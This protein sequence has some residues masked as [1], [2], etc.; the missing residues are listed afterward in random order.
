MRYKIA[1]IV[2]ALLLTLGVVGMAG[3]Q[4]SYTQFWSNVQMM[5]DV[6]IEEDLIVQDDVTI[7]DDLTVTDDATV[8]GILTVTE[9]IYQAVNTSE[10]VGLLPTVAS[11]DVITSTSG[12]IFTIADGE[13]WIVHGVLVAITEN[14]D[15]DGNDCTMTIGDGGDVDGLVVLADSEM[16]AAAVDVTGGAAGVHGY[17]SDTLGAY[18]ADSGFFMYAP[19]GAAETIDFA[20]GG[21]TPEGGAATVYIIYTRVE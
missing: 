18:L 1:A 12:A 21:T 11:V 19:S 4:G 15:C 14:F 2:L 9:E 10:N 5:Y 3:A 7:A 20:V 17:M 6:I 16:Q 8:T 13:V